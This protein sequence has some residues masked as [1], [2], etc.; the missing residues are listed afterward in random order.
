MPAPEASPLTTPDEDEEVVLG[1]QSIHNKEAT[2]FQTTNRRNRKIRKQFENTQQESEWA[3]VA[4]L[5]SNDKDN[6]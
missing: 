4:A 3:E 2:K 5:G 1:W 6:P